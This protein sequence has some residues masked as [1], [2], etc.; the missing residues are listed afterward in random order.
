MTVLQCLIH[1]SNEV[2]GRDRLLD[3]QIRANVR[4]FPESIFIIL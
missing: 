2:E 1:W 4:I 3:D